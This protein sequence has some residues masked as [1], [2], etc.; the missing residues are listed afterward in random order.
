LLLTPWDYTTSVF[1]PPDRTHRKVTPGRVFSCCVYQY[2]IH[3]RPS[4]LDRRS[5]AVPA[6]F[7]LL[8]CFFFCCFSFFYAGVFFVTSFCTFPW[9]SFPVFLFSLPTHIES[10]PSR[11]PAFLTS[12]NFPV[13]SPSAVF[14][15]IF[16]LPSVSKKGRFP[17]VLCA[18]ATSPPFSRAASRTFLR[19]PLPPSSNPCRNRTPMCHSFFPPPDGSTLP[20][21]TSPPPPPSPIP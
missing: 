11:M 6:P 9:P 14:H 5:S 13:P 1:P 15:P 16:P 8:L 18:Q 3:H 2:H 12:L 10:L 7:Q 4:P 21:S 19:P 20:R 17:G